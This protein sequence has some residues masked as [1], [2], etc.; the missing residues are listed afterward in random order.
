M[1]KRLGSVRMDVNVRY[2]WGLLN[3]S[4]SG[5]IAAEQGDEER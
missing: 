5:M 4:R 1:L 2:I 3:K